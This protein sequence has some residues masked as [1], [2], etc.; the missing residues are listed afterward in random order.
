MSENTP[1]ESASD[2]VDAGNDNDENQDTRDEEKVEQTH[3]QA[4]GL[5][6]NF[7]TGD[8]PFSSFRHLMTEGIEIQSDQDSVSSSNIISQRKSNIKIDDFRSHNENE[9]FHSLPTHLDDLTFISSSQSFISKLKRTDPKTILTMIF[10]LVAGVISIGAAMSLTASISLN[11]VNSKFSDPH[12]LT[13][14][15]SSNE[16]KKVVANANLDLPSRSPIIVWFFGFPQSENYYILHLIQHVSKRATATNSGQKVMDLD[17]VVH[18]AERDS[19]LLYENHGPALLS[20][21]SL[22]PPDKRVLTFVSNGDGTCLNCHPRNYMHNFAR[23]REV[24]SQ[25]S[26]IKNGNVAPMEYNPAIA[27]SAVHLFRN[28][29]DNILLR[30]WTE[31]EEM[32]L[33]H[34]D[35]ALKKYPPSH[36]GF[37]QWCNDRDAEWYALEKGWYGEDTMS[38]AEGVICR[39][40]FYKYV[41]YHNNVVKTR[42][43][44]DLPSLVLKYEDFNDQFEST[45]EKLIMFLEL[46]TES[47]PPE[48]DVKIN[49]SEKYYYTEENK[50]ATDAFMKSLAHPKVLQ[51]L[52]E[53]ESM[54]EA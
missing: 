45:I 41:M 39:Q 8:D 33:D 3:D 25:A 50:K 29:Y 11:V 35:F 30:F 22:D 44:L 47:E 43:T 28:P 15:S 18:I 10:L 5:L 51:V 52:E 23:F 26:F 38:L 6:G 4:D 19:I 54:S 46:P 42:Q 20:E 53:Y 16:I 49:F 17:G 13:S 24:C 48:K 34:R 36:Q 31:R 32:K 14:H 9:N 21:N 40:E 12:E 27:K 37:Q 1:M 7:E 2:N